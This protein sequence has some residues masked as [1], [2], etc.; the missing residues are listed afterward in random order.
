MTMQFRLRSLLILVAVIALLCI[1]SLQWRYIETLERRI[2]NEQKITADTH[3]NYY[4]R[5]RLRQTGRDLDVAIEGRGFFRMVDPSTE[6]AAYTRDGNLSINASG[7]LVVGSSHTGHPFVPSIQ[8]PNDAMRIE[9]S[10]KGDVL[11][12]LPGKTELQQVG[13]LQISKFD[14]PDGLLEIGEKMFSETEASGAA[15]MTMPGQDGAGVIHQR[16]LEWTD[17]DQI[18]ELIDLLTRLISVQHAVEVQTR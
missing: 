9:I 11:V 1:T 2:E 5:R 17:T 18:R 13:Q 4:L 6:A 15:Q 8:L 3:N 14:N 7:H 10:W 12:R 16:C